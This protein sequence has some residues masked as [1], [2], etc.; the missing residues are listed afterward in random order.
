[1]PHVGKKHKKT[2]KNKNKGPACPTR[3]IYGNSRFKTSTKT[4]QDTQKD[5][6][7]SAERRDRTS[8]RKKQ[9]D[10]KDQTGQAQR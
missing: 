10:Q 2:S 4:R 5:E 1:M 3:M 7:R 8:T 9:D 6:T